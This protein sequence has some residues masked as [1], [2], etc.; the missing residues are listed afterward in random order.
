MI[1]VVGAEMVLIVGLPRV[2]LFAD[3]TPKLADRV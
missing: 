2:S 3:I 1:V